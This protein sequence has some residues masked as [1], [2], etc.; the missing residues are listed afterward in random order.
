M[1]HSLGIFR[2]IHK[3]SQPR[4]HCQAPRQLQR[5]SELFPLNT[6]TPS[7]TT[8]CTSQLS[9]QY[10]RHL[11]V[12]PLDLELRRGEVLG[13]L[14]PNGAG[15]T[16]TLQMLT[17]NLAPSGGSVRIGGIDLLEE[18][19]AAKRRMGYLPET[20]PLYREFTV[21]EYLSFAARLHRIPSNRVQ[22]AVDRA[23]QRCGL[24]GV[25]NKMIGT[26]SKGYQ[27]RVGIAQA[28]I[29]EPDIIVLDEPTVGLDPNQLRDI[30]S[31]IRELAARSSII[32]STHILQEVEA[33]CD[34]VLILHHGTVIF[35]D[36][37]AGLRALTRERSL[38]LRLGAPPPPATLLAI[39]GVLDADRLADGRWRLRCTAE[40]DPTPQL[41]SKAAAEGWDLQELGTAGASLEEVFAQLTQGNPTP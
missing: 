38:I 23:S 13:L 16:T 39:P 8:L 21:S 27:Q 14:G 18:P 40:G 35:S 28:I 5:F 33:L 24:T 36:S 37:I 19:Q 17:G 26:L 20:P 9:R 3:A 22:E 25:I 31:M 29:H 41:V 15:K 11:A 32:L 2:G 34:R 10:G 30:R 12:K 1:R 4:A 6:V 7:E